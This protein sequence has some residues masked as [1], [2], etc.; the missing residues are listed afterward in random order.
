[1]KR[2]IISV[3][4]A[5]MLALSPVTASASSAELNTGTD[6]QIMNAI[7]QGA[8]IEMTKTP[9]GETQVNLVEPESETESERPNVE[10]PGMPESESSNR[11]PDGFWFSVRIWLPV[12][13]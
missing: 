1:M 3:I 10:V 4:L 7:S 8:E 5:A 12:G 11:F 13:I 9:S 6:N 2:R